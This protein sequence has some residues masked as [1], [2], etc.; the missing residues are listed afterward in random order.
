MK[1]IQL[2][3]LEQ[4]I[5]FF[6]LGKLDIKD[7]LSICGGTSNLANYDRYFDKFRIAKIIK[8]S[9][10]NDATFPN[11][12][13][14]TVNFEKY[15]DIVHIVKDNNLYF[16]EY[17]ENCQ[18]FAEIIDGQYRIIGMEKALCH[19]DNKQLERSFDIPFVIMPNLTTTD[20]ASIYIDI[21]SN[22]KQENNLLIYKLFG[23]NQ[24]RSI[25]KTCHIIVKTLQ[26]DKNSPLYGNI[27]M[28]VTLE[29]K[30]RMISQGGF[31]KM[32]VDLFS[33][34][35]DSDERLLKEEK[36]L[37]DKEEE[38]LI[39][40]LLFKNNQDDIIYKILFNYFTSIK[41]V[42]EKEWNDKDKYILLTEVGIGGMLKFL[43]ELFDIGLKEKKLSLS[44][45]V[46]KFTQISTKIDN[47]IFLKLKYEDINYT[48][49]KEYI[50]N[51]LKSALAE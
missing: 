16:L 38:K 21:N 27:K 45:F 40:R 7:L 15:K 14:L 20:M 10:E 8:Y 5:G 26:N 51:S 39:F 46:E 1:K 9:S 44:F 33:I 3:Q 6:Y 42:F 2:F 25:Q 24:N 11:T 28:L 18:G 30:Y 50:F 29:E 13:I 43:P 23:L 17:D 41:N 22:Q 12:I 36:V 49:I 31:S 32:L 34:D 19:S 35:L 37:S 48:D 47:D 4:P